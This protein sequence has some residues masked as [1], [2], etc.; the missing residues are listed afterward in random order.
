MHFGTDLR[1]QGQIPDYSEVQVNNSNNDNKRLM[2][3]YQ[4]VFLLCLSALLT[5]GTFYV[6]DTPSSVSLAIESHLY[7]FDSNSNSNKSISSNKLSQGGKFE[8]ILN[9][10][11]SSYSLPNVVLPLVFGALITSNSNSSIVAASKSLKYLVILPITICIGQML[12]SIGVLRRISFLSILGRFIIGC[13]AES[14]GVLQSFI[15]SYVCAANDYSHAWIGISL[16]LNIAVGRFGSLFDDLISPVIVNMFSSSDFQVGLSLALVYV[17]WVGLAFCAFSALCG[18]ILEHQLSTLFTQEIGQQ[19]QS[20]PIQLVENRNMGWNVITASISRYYITL[21]QL[22][23]A[24][25]LTGFMI[26]LAYGPLI[27]FTAIHAQLLKHK[28]EIKDLVTIGRLMSVGD[29]SGAVLGPLCGYLVDKQWRKHS[30]GSVIFTRLRLMVA[31]TT[32]LTCAHLLFALSPSGPTAVL[33]FT[34]LT[35]LLLLAISY[36]IILISWS[37]IPILLKSQPQLWSF[38]YGYAVS[39]LNLTYVVMPLVSGAIVS[40]DP[41]SPTSYSKVELF[42]AVVSFA[43]LLV[44]VYMYFVDLKYHG[45]VLFFGDYTPADALYK[46]LSGSDIHL[47]EVNS[48]VALDRRMNKDGMISLD[49]HKRQH[50]KS[51]DLSQTVF[52]IQNQ[53][54]ELNALEKQVL[55]NRLIREECAI[56]SLEL[57]KL[58]E[59]YPVICSVDSFSLAIQSN[60]LM[61]DILVQKCIVLAQEFDYKLLMEKL[62]QMHDINDIDQRKRVNYV[63]RILL[64]QGYDPFLLFDTS[65]AKCESPDCAYLSQTLC[66]CTDNQV[67]SDDQSQVVVTRPVKSSEHDSVVDTFRTSVIL[68]QSSFQSIKHFMRLFDCSNNFDEIVAAWHKVMDLKS[69]TQENITM[70]QDQKVGYNFIITEGIKSICQR[71]SQFIASGKIE[72]NRQLTQQA[73]S[74]NEQSADLSQDQLSP[75]EFFKCIQILLSCSLIYLEDYYSTNGDALISICQVISSI[76]GGVKIQFV[77]YMVQGYMK[78]KDLHHRFVTAL[79]HLLLLKK[80]FCQYYKFQVGNQEDLSK[81]LMISAARCL[82]ILYNIS[83]NI[84]AKYPFTESIHHFDGYQMND[85]I[86]FWYFQCTTMVSHDFIQQYSAGGCYDLAIQKYAA[87]LKDSHISSHNVQDVNR[88]YFHNLDLHLSADNQKRLQNNFS[89]LNYPF[90]IDTEMKIKLLRLESLCFMSTQFEDAFVNQGQSNALNKISLSHD[91]SRA[92]A[93]LK[94]SANPYLVLCVDRL[95]LINSTLQQ[96]Q[97]KRADLHK[98][99]KVQFI[100]EEGLDQGGVQKE[101]FQLCIEYLLGVDS[102]LFAADEDSE[103]LW[104][105]RSTVALEDLYWL[106][107]VL[108]GLALYN[109]VM[110]NLQFPL[111][112]YKYLLNVDHQPTFADYFQLKPVTGRNL[113]KILQWDEDLNG[114]LKDILCLNF[115]IQLDDGASVDLIRDG[116]SVEVDAQN[117]ELYVQKFVEY[118]MHTAVVDAIKSLHSGFWQ[119]I[120][121]PQF[122]THWQNV[123]NSEYPYV[124]KMLRPEELCIIL[125]GTLDNQ[126]LQMFSSE[127]FGTL[128]KNCVLDGGFT[129]DSPQI[130]A[131]WDIVLNQFSNYQRRKLYEFITASDRVPFDRFESIVISI[132]KNGTTSTR[133]PTSMA[134]FNRLLLPQYDTVEQMQRCLSLA[135]EE[136]KGFGLV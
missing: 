131:F 56:A 19:D 57:I 42:F 97:Q 40:S 45:G 36:S 74:V 54:L 12:F 77:T 120:S 123:N 109:N 105:Q 46:E 128:Q 110:I 51:E 9:L 101:F 8:W 7:P 115:T 136:S 116:G 67:Q 32:S 11:Y 25:H 37:F 52:R 104:M 117:R 65:G 95:N 53:E 85:L 39:L 71:L 23:L 113:L 96:L 112:M 124:V 1:S 31:C 89:I 22:P 21:I 73:A 92:I 86:P 64:N 121:G 13:C 88:L 2:P 33:S 26:L 119:V 68:E 4:T 55:I 100:N 3:Y 126:S 29:L 122:I 10:W 60:S 18:L 75:N 43:A 127:I 35:P 58:E 70:I 17:F 5:L 106:V 94:S 30:L 98:P 108:I 103:L 27:P 133:L 132:Q 50:T 78:V 81:C 82:S 118:H 49:H 47:D 91:S 61:T 69:G 62:S 24:V 135:I 16:A 90:L 66:L 107:G 102:R 111:I 129:K 28:F 87:L 72:L 83:E 84:A 41:Q 80:V 59:Y 114:S 99:L 63:A 76:R 79:G 38:A 134:C 14:L 20:A 6:Y 44:C 15:T 93:L 48:Q 130:I 125:C 34:I